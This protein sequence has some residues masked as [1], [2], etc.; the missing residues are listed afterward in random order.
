MQKATRAAALMLV[1]LAIG[2]L[3]LAVILGL[4]GRTQREQMP[5]TFSMRATAQQAQVLVAARDL[6]AGEP[7]DANDL[8]VA[9]VPSMPPDTYADPARLAGKI[10]AAP[11]AGGTVIEARMLAHGL[12]LQLQPGERALA[13]PVDELAGAGNRIVPGD[14]VD[15]FMSLKPHGRDDEDSQNRLLLSR[16]R[17]LSY[18]ADDHGQAPAPQADASGAAAGSSDARADS[19]ASRDGSSSANTAQS[20][21]SAVLAVPVDQANRLLLA[22][23][24]GK[25]FLALRHPSDTGNPDETLFP[26]ARNVLSPRMDLS[27]ERREA[28]ASPENDAFAGLDAAGLA[29]RGNTPAPREIGARTPAPRRSG[30]PPLE[31]IRGGQPAPLSPP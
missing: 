5:Q 30:A 3:L 27:P 7:L 31:I 25:L 6:P 2:L 13:V 10:L 12:A 18:G 8:R 1:A 24:S 9:N 22:A 16:L 17:V 11:I 21:R 23:Q 19:I 29:G 28:T 26:R 14:Y 15:I 4:R 20:A